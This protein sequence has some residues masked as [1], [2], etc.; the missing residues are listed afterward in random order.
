VET[1][2]AASI[3]VQ[4]N[5]F[6]LLELWLFAL[7][8][9]EVYDRKDFFLHG[10]HVHE[11]GVQQ[12]GVVRGYVVACLEASVKVRASRNT[13]LVTG[14]IESVWDMESLEVVA[15]QQFLAFAGVKENNVMQVA[16]R[17]DICLRAIGAFEV[18]GYCQYRTVTAWHYSLLEIGGHSSFSIGNRLEVPD[19][20]KV[21][22]CGMMEKSI[23]R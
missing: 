5:S 16:T 13:S 10:I 2:R 11:L 15:A 6:R 22:V 18:R 3:D 8:I 9:L 14:K 1:G 23:L 4:C 12:E 20:V 19:L 17:V 7:Q 21:G